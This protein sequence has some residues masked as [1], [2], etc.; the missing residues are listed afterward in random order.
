MKVKYIII[1]VLLPMY[2]FSQDLTGEELLAKS[3]SYHDP[4]G[5]WDSWKGEFVIELEMENRPNR[6]SKVLL[7]N[8]KG[9]FYLTVNQ[10]DHTITRKTEGKECTTLLDGKEPTEYDLIKKYR[11]TCERTT[12]YRDYYT[13]LYGLPMKLRD[14]GTVIHEQVE[15]ADM[16]GKTYLKLKVTYDAAVGKDIW[17]FYFDENTYALRA[18]QFYH[19]EAKNDGEYILLE[20]E[21]MING[22]T[23][24]K[25]RTWYYNKDGKLLGTDFLRN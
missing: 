20:G 18:Y 3:I 1:L 6:R 24:P 19:D 4:K 22:I 16:N 13:Y 7:D 9:L 5:K 21:S 17:Y 23:F 11:L 14:E 15:R 2:V 10:D 8:K 12:M 25:D